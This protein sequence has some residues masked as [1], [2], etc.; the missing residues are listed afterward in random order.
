MSCC[1]TSRSPDTTIR[2]GPVATLQPF[3]ISQQ[4]AAHPGIDPFLEKDTFRPPTINSPP[5]AHSLSRFHGAQSPPPSSTHGSIAPSP[6]LSVSQM[7][8]FNRSSV[9]ESTGSLAPLRRPTPA[10]ATPGN[11][12]LLSTYQSP[13]AVAPSLP[14][15]D[16]GK[17]SVSIDF[18]ERRALDLCRVLN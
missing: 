13:T 1:G 10:Y 17:M 11:P 15:T 12:N 14:T 4:P 5:Q 9:I 16:E 6:P 8:T 18:G 7:G 3:P 2:S